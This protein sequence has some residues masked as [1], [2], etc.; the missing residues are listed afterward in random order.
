MIRVDLGISRYKLA[1]LLKTTPKDLYYYEIG[2]VPSKS[3]LNRLIWVHRLLP[4]I[5]VGLSIWRRFRIAIARLTRYPR[6]DAYN[7]YLLMM[8]RMKPN[9]QLI[10]PCC[11]QSRTLLYSSLASTFLVRSGIWIFCLIVIFSGS[12]CFSRSNNLFVF[13]I[14]NNVSNKLYIDNSIVNL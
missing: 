12:S 1:R 9:E 2:K 4:I 14:H 8:G 13:S 11:V 3:F 6:H 7:V 10:L 5:C